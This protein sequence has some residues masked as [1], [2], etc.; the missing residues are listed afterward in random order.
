MISKLKR[1]KKETLDVVLKIIHNETVV[2][3]PEN[4]Y[5]LYIIVTSVV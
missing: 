4:N 2:L 5:L 3:L 1:S